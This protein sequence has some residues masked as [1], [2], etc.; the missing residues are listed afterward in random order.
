MTLSRTA[1]SAFPATH[2]LPL[3]ASGLNSYRYKGRYG[4]VM[5]CAASVDKA[6]QEA[7]RSVSGPVSAENLQVWNGKAYQAL[8]EAQ[9]AA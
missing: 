7:A 3:A 5:I 1:A 4:F 2:E 9:P 8:Q 6:L